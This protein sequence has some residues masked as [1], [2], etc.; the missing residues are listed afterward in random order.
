MRKVYID[1]I[2]KNDREGMLRPLSIEWE[3]GEVFEIDRL[4]D[5]RKAA[6]TK[7][8]GCGMR[9]T[10]VINGKEKFLFH[11]DDKW[12]VEAIV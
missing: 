1:V 8:G 2:L 10:V 7:V 6:S 11:E 5:R 9:Y 12:F 4:I 3:N